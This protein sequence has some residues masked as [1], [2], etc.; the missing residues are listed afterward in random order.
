MAENSKIKTTAYPASALP[1]TNKPL[2]GQTPNVDPW[3]NTWTREAGTSAVGEPSDATEVTP[4]AGIDQN[5]IVQLLRTDDAGG[6]ALA[7]AAQ[8]DLI[9]ATLNKILF[10]LS[11]GLNVEPPGEMSTVVEL[12]EVA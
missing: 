1:P 11:L 7:Q 5:T 12:C 10:V 3:G 2:Y 4:V 6:V 8:L 9:L